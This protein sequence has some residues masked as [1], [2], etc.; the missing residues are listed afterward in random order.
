MY[1]IDINFIRICNLVRLFVRTSGIDE[2]V[3]HCAF[4]VCIH[5]VLPTTYLL[6][7]YTHPICSPNL[8]LEQRVLA[9]LAINVR[10]QWI[11]PN[12]WNIFQYF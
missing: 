12:K 10:C 1:F 2:P 8:K 3:D 5:D 7:E 6:L 4:P 9:L 11:S